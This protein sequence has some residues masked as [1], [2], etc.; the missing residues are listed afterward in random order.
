MHIDL[1]GTYSK[2][3]RQQKPGGAITKKYISLAW[4]TIIGTAMGWFKII[5]VPCFNLDEVER[6]NI[7]YIDKLSAGVRHVFNKA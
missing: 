5:E 4:I 3:T 6:V 1:I 7:E 2:S